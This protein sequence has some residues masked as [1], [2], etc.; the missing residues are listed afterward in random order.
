ML[1]QASRKNSHSLPLWKHRLLPPKSVPIEDRPTK[2]W[3]VMNQVPEI[4]VPHPKQT[5]M[6]CS[7]TVRKWDQKVEHQFEESMNRSPEQLMALS[8]GVFFQ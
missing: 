4:V 5:G 3:L 2:I 7:I 6:Q 8:Y 1:R